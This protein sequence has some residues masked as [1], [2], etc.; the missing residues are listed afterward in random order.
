M[1]TRTR[2]IS[3]LDMILR[4]YKIK[5]QSL[6][7]MLERPK[8]DPRFVIATRNQQQ[9]QRLNFSNYSHMSSLRNTR[10]FFSLKATNERLQARLD[11]FKQVVAKC[12]MTLVE[13][14]GLMACYQ[15]SVAEA[16]KSSQK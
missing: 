1:R 3:K 2:K 14:K 13:N 15:A 5:I 9:S 6:R 10:N 4:P 16:M 12:T 7:E 11:E 8:K